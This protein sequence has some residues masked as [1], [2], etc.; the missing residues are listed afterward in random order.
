M[1]LYVATAL[2]SSALFVPFVFMKDY[3]TDRGDQQHGGD[4]ARQRDRGEQRDRAARPRRARGTAGATR[5]MQL[6]FGVM[7]ASFLIWLT[8]GDSYPQ[9]VLFAIEQAR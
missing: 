2:I 3:A 5:L 8:A 1:I 7:A 9:L 4:G 6:S